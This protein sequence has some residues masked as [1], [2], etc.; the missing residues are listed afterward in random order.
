MN[1]Q[2]VN[3]HLFCKVKS[4][5]ECLDSPAHCDTNNSNSENDNCIA[6]VVR[7]M[8]DISNS[9]VSETSNIKSV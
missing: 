2:I 4:E 3:F 7:R 6:D 9:I 1:G 5:G 8:N